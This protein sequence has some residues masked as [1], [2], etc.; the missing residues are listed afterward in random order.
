MPTFTISKDGQTLNTVKLEG[1]RI[2]LGSANTCK[3]FIDDLLISLHQA[4]R[5]QAPSNDEAMHDSGKH[6]VSS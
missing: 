2:E 4:V 1:E 6:D 5:P 3:L